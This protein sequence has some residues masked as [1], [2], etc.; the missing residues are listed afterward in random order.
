MNVLKLK[1][2]IK[3]KTKKQEEQV[4][5][6]N[7]KTNGRNRKESATLKSVI[8][9][10]TLVITGAAASAQG[11]WKTYLENNQETA[12][13][14]AEANVASYK[15]VNSNAA[16][17]A[18]FAAYLVEE[19]EETLEVEE[20]MTEADNFGTFIDIEEETESPLQLEDWML[21]EKSFEV[22][23]ENEEPLKLETWMT[24]ENVWK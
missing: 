17:L 20:W 5:K 13:L 15:A 18:S 19:K 6:T 16:T 23:N 2:K 21:N 4:M 1:Q 3:Q 7:F 24:A 14:H 11:V 8:I 10:A 22:K 9:A 12:Y